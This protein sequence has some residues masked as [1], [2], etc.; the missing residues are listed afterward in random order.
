MIDCVFLMSYV[1]CPLLLLGK[2]PTKNQVRM[3]TMI[4]ARAP[5]TMGKF[6]EPDW[7]GMGVGVG[8]GVLVSSSVNSFDPEL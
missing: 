8:V 2:Y 4:I 5:M 6:V 7:I 1:C 3:I